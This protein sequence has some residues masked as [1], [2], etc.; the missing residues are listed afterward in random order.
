M[1]SRPGGV[2]G[3]DE[4]RS[5]A[6]QTC[7]LM[8]STAPRRRVPAV[9]APASCP[10]FPRFAL[11]RFATAFAWGAVARGDDG[12]ASSVP[13]EPARRGRRLLPARPAHPSPRVR[14]I[15][16]CASG[17]PTRRVFTS[18]EPYDRTGAV[19]HATA[20]GRGSCPVAPHF[21][22]TDAPRRRG[23]SHAAIRPQRHTPRAGGPQSG[24]ST[25][26][27]TTASR[28]VRDDLAAWD[29]LEGLSE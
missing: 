6:H 5:S 14:L 2:D 7:S 29:I 24:R 8:T 19:G 20:S 11:N 9:S 28:S 1:S 21:P 15:P 17:S 23:V 25:A 4:L 26:A 3:V 27:T 10:Y 16:P 13:V 22:R 12:D 18:V